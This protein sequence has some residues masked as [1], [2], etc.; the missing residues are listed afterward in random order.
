[1]KKVT[2]E[3]AISKA[4]PDSGKQTFDQLTRDEAKSVILSLN[5]TNG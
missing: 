3:H 5:N 4:L 2:P 1:M